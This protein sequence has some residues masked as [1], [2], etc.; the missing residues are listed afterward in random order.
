MRPNF[1]KRAVPLSPRLCAS[2]KMVPYDS[3]NKLKISRWL[4]QRH[5]AYN[6]VI[7]GRFI[8]GVGGRETA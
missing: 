1:F 5:W 3:P 7:T 4:R 6:F 2:L 8:S